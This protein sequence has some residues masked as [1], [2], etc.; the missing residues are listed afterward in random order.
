[1]CHPFFREVYIEL[2]CH[3]ISTH[4][5]I[6]MQYINLQIILFCCRFHKTEKKNQCYSTYISAKTVQSNTCSMIFSMAE[7]FPL[8]KIGMLMT[9]WSCLNYKGCSQSKSVTQGGTSGACKH[10]QLTSPLIHDRTEK[11]YIN[12]Q[13]VS[14]G[15]VNILGGSMDYSE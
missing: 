8:R 5:K 12:I 14:G 7:P 2:K 15:I 4:I 10:D 13:G 6:C 3:Y 9:S 1:M 11:I